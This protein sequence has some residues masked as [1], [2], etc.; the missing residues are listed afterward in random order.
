MNPSEMPQTKTA[1]DLH[2]EK[3]LAQ[4]RKTAGQ[5]VLADKLARGEGRP[6]PGG[7]VE[8]AK[9]QLSPRPVAESAAVPLDRKQ[10]LSDTTNPLLNPL[11][12]ISGPH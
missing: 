12:G 7:A 6:L 5:Q 10:S 3:L 1:A 4:S 8:T 9:F 2:V 11:E